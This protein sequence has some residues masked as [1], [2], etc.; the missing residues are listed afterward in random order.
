[1]V[2]ICVLWYVKHLEATILDNI[3]KQLDA[4]PFKKNCHEHIVIKMQGI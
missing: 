3:V 2:Y 4:C 1:M